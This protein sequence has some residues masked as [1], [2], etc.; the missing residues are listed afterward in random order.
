MIEI[1]LKLPVKF[2][3]PHMA[4]RW[5]LDHSVNFF[6]LKLASHLN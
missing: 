6:L 5:Y 2:Q 1:L 3:P 4:R